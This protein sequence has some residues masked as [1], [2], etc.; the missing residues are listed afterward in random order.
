MGGVRKTFKLKKK[1]SFILIETHILSCMIAPL[2][3]KCTLY[4]ICL[5]HYKSLNA[6][7]FLA[8]ES[9]SLKLLLLR[10]YSEHN[11]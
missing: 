5:I 2:Q 6:E 4:I 9:Q 8:C 7:A 11:T 3:T 10:N 1:K